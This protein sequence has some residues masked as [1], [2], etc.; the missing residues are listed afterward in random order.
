M[1]STGA[2]ES[3]WFQQIQIL[4]N[5]EVVLKLAAPAGTN[6]QVDASAD[7]SSWTPLVTLPFASGM[8][9]YTD[10]A[11]PYLPARIYRAQQRGETNAIT[12]DHLITTAGEVVIRPIDHAS[13]VL[14]WNRTNAIYNDPV[15]PATR[16]RGLPLAN[17]IL[18]AHEHSDH[19]EAATINAVK[20]S[21]AIIIAPSV[22]HRT[23]SAA[24]K[25]ITTVLTNGG[26]TEVM[27]ITVTAIPAYNFIA[28]NHPKGVGNGYVLTLGDQRIYLSGDTEDIPEMRALTDIDV[29]FIC[30]NLPYTMT[31]A[32]AASAVREF[33]PRIVYPYHFRGSDVNSFKRQVGT[34]LGIEVRLRKWY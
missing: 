29:A 23:L 14:V 5:R 7:L 26:S 15:G 18:I 9:Q 11:A 2:Q 12:G 13:L 32:Q 31:V 21:N 4:T 20:A 25:G 22:V 8:N 28:P 27:G 19:L 34:D 16:Y 30:M 33:R 3:P 1:A 6:C 24:L 17:L 10:S